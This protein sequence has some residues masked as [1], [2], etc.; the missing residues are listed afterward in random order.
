M[1]AEK[2]KIFKVDWSERGVFKSFLFRVI[3]GL[4]SIFF[5]GQIRYFLM[6]ERGVFENF[7]MIK[8]GLFGFRLN[9]RF[10]NVRKG[11]F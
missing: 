10:F 2:N 1:V 3:D 7:F 11:L 5:Q 4:S 9:K 6:S 8:D